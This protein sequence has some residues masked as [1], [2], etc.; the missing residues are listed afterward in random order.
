MKALQVTAEWKP[1]D[2][3]TPL[4]REIEDQRAMRGN[5]I[6][7][8]P[9]LE[10]VDKRI[11]QCKDNEVLL[12]IGAC[13]VCGSDTLFIG[14]D[15]EGYTHYSSH[16]KF[17]STVG[18]E[19]CGEVVEVGKDVKTLKKG[20]I[21]SGENMNWC[22]ECRY[23]RMGMFN[24]CERLEE[25]GFSLD[26]AFAEYMAVKEKHCY[27]VNDLMDVYHTKEKVFEAGA[28]IEPMAVAY[29]GIFIRG[30]GFLPGGSVAV[31]GC[32]PVGLAA[33]ALLRT[34]GASKIIAL[35]LSEERLGLAR[36]LG[37][38][39]VLNPVQLSKEG[40]SSSDA[41]LEL[42]KG[43]GAALLAEVT[44]KQEITIPEMEKAM[45][46]GGKIIQ[47][48]ISS[49]PTVITSSHFQKKGAS[50]Y[51]TNGNAGHGIF[52][53]VIELIAG[54]RIEISGIIANRSSLYNAVKAIEAAKG[55]KGG[56]YIVMPDKDK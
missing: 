16:C 5:L 39:H 31:F 9:V 24:Q 8:N 45:A 11:P 22:G 21:V 27:I 38:D 32:G 18:H 4:K 30:G 28:L 47:I 43:N 36:S 29:N 51:G 12:K 37:A 20:D 2:G 14:K 7:H 26:G 10:L 15:E 33:I 55:A 13:G 44:E 34:S 50:Y 19:F 54:G 53:N 49:R 25:I 17:P 46:V 35:D 52:G 6:Y 3:Y 23:C 42:T 41:I 1:R 48:G 56:K 40:V